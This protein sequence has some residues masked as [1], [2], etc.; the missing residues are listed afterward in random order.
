MVPHALRELIANAL[1]EAALTGSA[2]PVIDKDA[3]DGSWHVRDFGRGLRHEHLTQK[4]DREKLRRADLVV[5][6]FGVGLKPGS[7]DELG[8]SGAETTN[9]VPF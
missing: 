4:E 2:E 7:T 6:K 9:Q 8:L 5:G 1:D 3:D